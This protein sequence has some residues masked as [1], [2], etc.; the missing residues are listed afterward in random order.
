MEK[1]K[2][3]LL[4]VVTIYGFWKAILDTLLNTLLYNHLSPLEDH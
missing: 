2:F 1:S 4:R 3:I